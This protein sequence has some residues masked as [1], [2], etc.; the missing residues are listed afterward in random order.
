MRIG[1]RELVQRRK[2]MSAKDRARCR[3]CTY[4][5]SSIP[6]NSPCP[7]CGQ[8]NPTAIADF[9]KDGRFHLGWILGV[10][11]APLV[12]LWLL[13]L[14]TGNTRPGRGLE[15]QQF[16]DLVLDP[17]ARTTHAA[18]ISLTVSMRAL[19]LG[20]ILCATMGGLFAV[21]GCRR[22]RSLMLRIF[23]VCAIACPLTWTLGVFAR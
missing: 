23:V 13:L 16:V 10:S 15:K 6:E 7:E 17:L 22:Q 21:M 19:I 11:M 9:W 12:A 18:G 5:C 2:E 4:D 20:P 3:G 1:Y 14:P 8:A